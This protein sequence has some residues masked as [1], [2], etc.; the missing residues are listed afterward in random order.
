MN[1]IHKPV[2]VVVGHDPHDGENNE[3]EALR[4]ILEREYDCRVLVYNNDFRMSQCPEFNWHS[5]KGGIVLIFE[6]SRDNVVQEYAIR[7]IRETDKNVSIISEESPKPEPPSPPDPKI[8]A[9]LEEKFGPREK[10][11]EKP[12]YD[13]NADLR[14]QIVSIADAWKVIFPAIETALA[15]FKAKG[16]NI[17]PYQSDSQSRAVYEV[18]LKKLNEMKGDPGAYNRFREECFYRVGCYYQRIVNGFAIDCKTLEFAVSKGW[19]YHH[20]SIQILKSRLEEIEFY[21]EF[22]TFNRIQA[23]E[24]PTILWGAHLYESTSRLHDTVS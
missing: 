14:L 24:R 23:P 22:R 20:Y 10:P 19:G 18:E 6:K 9:I 1:T 17:E 2:V 11:I 8:E 12:P 21:F 3:G 13:F 7:F 5:K 4:Y 16:I 15:E